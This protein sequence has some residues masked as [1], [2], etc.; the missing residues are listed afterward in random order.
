MIFCQSA[1]VH[2]PEAMIKSFGCVWVIRQKICEVVPA[3]AK[4]QEEIEEK[5][6][7]FV[8][9]DSL[10]KKKR[11]EESSE[12]TNDKK[13]EEEEEKTQPS[14]AKEKKDS[15]AK[16]KALKAEKRALKKAKKEA[17]KAKKEK[18]KNK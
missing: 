3:R 4:N 8:E 7:V 9:W 11:E 6:E 1:R 16:R 14:V 18:K 5:K 13:E 15:K 2:I 12:T 17:K 10:Q